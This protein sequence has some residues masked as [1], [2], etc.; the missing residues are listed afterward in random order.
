MFNENK[1]HK[2][3]L[4]KWVFK[5][6]EDLNEMRNLPE[7][8]LKVIEI[9]RSK[10]EENQEDTISEHLRRSTEENSSPGTLPSSTTNKATSFLI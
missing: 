6:R 10:I 7:S 3:L 5:I 2:K 9:L 8:C 4:K 1:K